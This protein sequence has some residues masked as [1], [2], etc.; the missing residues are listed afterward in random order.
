VPRGAFTLI[1]LL[2]VIAILAILI[3][4]L[5][6]AVQGARESAS[7]TQCANNLHQIAT[8]CH[9][10]H[11]DFGKLPY[12]NKADVL[13]SYNWSQAILPFIEQENVYTQYETIDSPITQTND[14]PGANPFGSGTNLGRTIVIKTYR[15]PSTLPPPTN[16]PWSTYYIRE[17]GNYRAC[18]GSGDVYGNVITPGIAAGKG[19]FSITQGQIYLG[20][21][22]A[23]QTRLTDITDGTTETVMFSEA[24]TPNIEVW[25]TIGDLTLGNMGGSLFSTY[26]TPNTTAPDSIWG[27]CPRD[28]GDTIYTAPCQSKGGPNRPPGNSAGNQ[29][30]AYAGARSN[31]PDGVNVAMGDASVRFVIN[32]IPAQTWWALGTKAGSEV[33]GDF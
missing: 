4:L 24:L 11:A 15:C 19:I 26:L 31:H 7:R 2:V 18:V 33:V 14:W 27:P 6:P 10:Y 29:A 8:A 25:S 21:I 3:A 12:G 5:L 32:N 16:E 9:N 17:R 23:A 1:E 13:D 30:G 20:P 22:P 28:Q